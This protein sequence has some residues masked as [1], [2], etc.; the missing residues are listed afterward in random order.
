MFLAKPCNEI[1]GRVKTRPAPTY[2]VLPKWPQRKIALLGPDLVMAIDGT[3]SH[4]RVWPF[5]LSLDAD[6]ML[7]FVLSA[8]VVA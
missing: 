7:Q 4:P 2:G 3:Q 5:G 6:I 8:V 1:R